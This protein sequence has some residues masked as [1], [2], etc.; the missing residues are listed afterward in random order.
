MTTPTKK[1][2]PAEVYDTALETGMT[3]SAVRM[4]LSRADAYDEQARAS[5]A[6]REAEATYGYGSPEA[7]AA[8]DAS[9]R[10]WETYLGWKHACTQ[11][12]LA[13]ALD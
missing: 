5:R 3:Q 1:H 4:S 6:A 13:G 7:R 9:Q 8:R 11:A 10:A 12:A 2:D